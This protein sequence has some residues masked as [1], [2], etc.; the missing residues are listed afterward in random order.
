[1]KIFAGIMLAL[2]ASV[3]VGMSGVLVY[4]KIKIKKQERAKNDH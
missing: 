1:M 4:R 3:L 2:L